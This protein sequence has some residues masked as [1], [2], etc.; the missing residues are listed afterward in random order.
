MAAPAFDDSRLDDPV[1]LQA[2]DDQLRQ[3]ASA[4]AR[5]RVLGDAARPADPAWLEV[6]PRGVVAL[7]AEARLVRAMLEPV[8]PV[9][10]VA[11]PAGGLPGW[12]GPLDL[13]VVLASEG[14]EPDLMGTVA[15]A[16]R[17]GALLQVAA[18]PDSPIA[19]RAASRNTFV[20]PTG[21]S[22]PLA[23]V[24]VTL[25]VLHQLGLGPAVSHQRVADQADLVAEQCSPHRDL[26][27]NPAKDLAVALAEAQPLVWGGSVL[28]ARAARRIAEALRRASGRPAL[29]ADA[30]ALLPVLEACQPRDPFRDPFDEESATLPGVLLLVDD[31]VLDERVRRER[32]QLVSAAER[33]GV[34]VC[35]IGSGTAES[36]SSLDR[37]VELLQRGRYAASYLALGLAENE[38]S[39]PR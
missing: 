33:H 19:E 3:L 29:A 36:L 9:P 15:E 18:N 37:Y 35:E 39:I 14:S 31:G 11:W 32:G 16:V 28:A 17:R 8:C 24:V 26:A 6:R 12:V 1:A 7:G 4:G 21:H 13:V 34:R 20:L 38:G 2:I 22:D 30:S 5:V 25:E 27:Q 23:T 10:F